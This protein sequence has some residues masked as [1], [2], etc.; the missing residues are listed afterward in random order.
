MDDHQPGALMLRT[1]I[2]PL[3]GTVLGALIRYFGQCSSGTCRLTS[4][5]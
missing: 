4:T 3:I 2:P 5:W 1:L